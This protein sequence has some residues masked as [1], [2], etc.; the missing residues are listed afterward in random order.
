MIWDREVGGSNPLAPTNNFNSLRL[1]S[2]AAVFHLW[3]AGTRQMLGAILMDG[4]DR[5]FHDFV[6]KRYLRRIW[7]LPARSV[8]SPEL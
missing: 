6:T 8:R 5:V 7:M 1:L 2:L 3:P 4:I